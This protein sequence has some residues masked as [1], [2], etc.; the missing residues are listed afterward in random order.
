MHYKTEIQSRKTA[1]W[2]LANAK[3]QDT[4]AVYRNNANI[5]LFILKNH[6]IYE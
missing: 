3:L 5:L 4:T 2:L 1:V 6:I